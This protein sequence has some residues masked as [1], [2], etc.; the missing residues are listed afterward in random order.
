[1][2]EYRWVETVVTEADKLD[3]LGADGWEAIGLTV[4]GTHFGRTYASVLMKRA[5]TADIVDLTVAE[6][7]EQ[8]AR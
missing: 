8:L 6:V 3:A 1:M 5:R 4:T 2:F 7:P